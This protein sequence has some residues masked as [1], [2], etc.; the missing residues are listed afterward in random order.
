MNCGS[1]GKKIRKYR[2]KQNL[3]QEQFAELCE[4][5]TNFIGIIE[6]GEKRPSLDTFVKIANALDVSADMLLEDELQRLAEGSPFA[7]E[8]RTLSEEGRR[9]VRNITE[10]AVAFA[11]EMGKQ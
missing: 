3:T 1:V 5:S 2:K 9:F 7:A 8:I 11:K 6:R 10:C 4:L